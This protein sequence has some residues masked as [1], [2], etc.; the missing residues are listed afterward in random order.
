[1][2]IKENPHSNLDKNM[3]IRF[4]NSDYLSKS[5][6]NY[7][8]CKEYEGIILLTQLTRRLDFKLHVLK[9]ISLVYSLMCVQSLRGDSD[10]F[11]Q[12]FVINLASI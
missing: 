10:R 6:L 3:K 4:L 1:M 8:N 12:R 5:D 7:I 9:S 11:L 2:K